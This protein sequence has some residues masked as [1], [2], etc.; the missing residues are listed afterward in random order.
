[1]TCMALM[2]QE[3]AKT[4]FH[5]Q[6]TFNSL[7]RT[8]E[9]LDLLLLREGLGEQDNLAMDAQ[10]YPNLYQLTFRHRSIRPRSYHPHFQSRQNETDKFKPRCSLDIP[11]VGRSWSISRAGALRHLSGASLPIRDRGSVTSL[12]EPMDSESVGP[13]TSTN[14]SASSLIASATS[15][16]QFANSKAYRQLPPNEGS[17]PPN[18]PEEQIKRKSLGL[19]STISLASLRT[20]RKIIPPQAT[21][22]NTVKSK[23]LNAKDRLH[24]IAG[25]SPGSTQSHT[26]HFSKWFPNMFRGTEPPLPSTKSNTSTRRS[27]TSKPPTLPALESIDYRIVLTT[28][29]E[30]GST[31]DPDFPQERFNPLMGMTPGSSASL[32]TV[33]YPNRGRL[34]SFASLLEASPLTN[35]SPLQNEIG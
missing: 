9:S 3:V 20:L 6:G 22:A 4:R 19:R 35:P 11:Q 31:F 26:S 32:P 16:V 2:H 34:P 21:P 25:S 33:S 7:R 28:T 23:P 29:N 27:K 24:Q 18:N 5:L 8:R 17:Q 1:M 30:D 13:E 14:T 12:P 15:K 10:S